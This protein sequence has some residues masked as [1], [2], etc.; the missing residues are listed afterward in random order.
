VALSAA[1]GL[2]IASHLLHGCRHLLHSRRDAHHLLGL[3]ISPRRHLVS[4]RA[5][6]RRPRRQFQGVIQEATHNQAEAILEGIEGCGQRTD[7]VAGG[8]GQARAEVGA[9]GGERP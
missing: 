5:H 7:L 8:D 9:A 3:A 6:P 1:G 4:G 2:G